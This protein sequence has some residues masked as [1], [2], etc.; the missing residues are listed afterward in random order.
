MFVF[1]C[2]VLLRLQGYHHAVLYS[3]SCLVEDINLINMDRF[4]GEMTCTAK[5][6]YRQPDKDV[7]IQF[8]G[9][10]IFVR[11]AK[12][13]RAITPGQAAVFYDGDVCLGGGFIKEAYKNNQK[14]QY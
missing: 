1:E 5:F 13:V 6:R 9:E 12:D 11:F 4:E 10:N 2:Y 14:R 7:T 3:D 8:I